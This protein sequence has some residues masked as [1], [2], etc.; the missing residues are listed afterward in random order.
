M[1]IKVNVIDDHRG[2]KQILNLFAK[3]FNAIF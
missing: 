2:K 1:G 3:Q